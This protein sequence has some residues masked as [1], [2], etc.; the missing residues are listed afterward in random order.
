MPI[1][2]NEINNFNEIGSYTFT[3]PIYVYKLI[4]EATGAGGG[5]GQA[6]A[7]GKGATNGGGG[8]ASGALI[9]KTLNVKPGQKVTY[10]IGAGGAG[11]S[12]SDG[13][14]GSDTTFSYRETTYTADGGN[15]GSDATSSAVGVAGAATTPTG[16]DTNTVGTAGGDGTAGGA[17]IAGTSVSGDGYGAGGVG[18]SNTSQNNAAGGNGGIKFTITISTPTVTIPSGREYNKKNM[19]IGG[20]KIAISEDNSIGKSRI[21][22]AIISDEVALSGTTTK[23]WIGGMGLQTMQTSNGN[24]VLRVYAI[25]DDTD[26]YPPDSFKQSTDA[27]IFRGVNV[28]V[29]YATDGKYV[30]AFDRI[31]NQEDL[32][33]F[34]KLNSDNSVKNTI[35]WQGTPVVVN[36]YN[37]LVVSVSDSSVVDEF[38][39]TNFMGFPFLIARQGSDYLLC[40]LFDDYGYASAPDNLN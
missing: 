14:A 15:G 1:D 19:S 23:L 22:A 25:G 37:A 30:L 29:F 27:S 3:V 7:P 33:G 20:N 10:T 4:V 34:G 18:S 17:G 8:G 39:T 31:E 16:G 28:D 26:A 36:N 13:I 38:V 40:A 12:G 9:I 6:A 21:Q 11:S 5:G 32:T 24:Y 2:T 35:M